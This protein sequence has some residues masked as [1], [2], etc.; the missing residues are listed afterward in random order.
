MPRI[1]RR[2]THLLPA[3]ISRSRI[4]HCLSSALTPAAEY[5]QSVGI[6]KD[7]AYRKSDV[8]FRHEATEK[9]MSAPSCGKYAHLYLSFT[10]V[11]PRKIN[12]ERKKENNIGR[13]RTLVASLRMKQGSESSVSGGRS[14]ERKQRRKRKSFLETVKKKKLRKKEEKTSERK[15]S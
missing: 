3:C 9:A 8:A 2:A 10:R 15:K 6:V 13:A 4:P 5:G 12:K 1:F 7:A 11:S 14:G